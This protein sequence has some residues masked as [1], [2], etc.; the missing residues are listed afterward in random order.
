MMTDH[1]SHSQV[2]GQVAAAVEEY[3]ASDNLGVLLDRLKEITGR[4]SAEDLAAAAEPYSALPEVMIPIFEKVVQLR[5]DDSRALVRLA[6]AYWLTGR[7]PEVVGRLVA[8]AISG[9][10]ENR[11]AWHLWAITEP[12]LRQRVERWRQVAERF[13]SDQLA[14]AALADNAASLA[15]EERDPLALDLAIRTYEGLLAEAEHPTTRSALT[16][17]LEALRKWRV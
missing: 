10:A 5:P 15:S 12:D 3:Q 13:P 17:A 8:R 14:R 6:N 11:G 16:T 7:G 1:P 9:D 4:S 2:A